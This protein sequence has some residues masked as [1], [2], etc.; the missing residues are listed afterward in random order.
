MTL[1]E[2]FEISESKYKDNIIYSRVVF[3]NESIRNNYLIMDLG[4]PLLDEGEKKHIESIIEQPIERTKA[5]EFIKLYNEDGLHH[6]IKNVEYW[7]RDTFK[8]L[9]SFK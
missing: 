4:N 2:V 6:T 5:A 7:I 3:N 9:N 1:E 8:V